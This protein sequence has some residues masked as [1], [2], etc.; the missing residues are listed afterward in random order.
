LLVLVVLLLLAPPPLPPPPLNLQAAL[1]G[2]GL[3]AIIMSLKSKAKAKRIHSTKIWDT[4]FKV[5]SSH[6]Q[7]YHSTHVCQFN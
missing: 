6:V 1:N 3:P 2:T 5:T 7:F 4:K